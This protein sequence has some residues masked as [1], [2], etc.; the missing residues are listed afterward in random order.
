MGEEVISS[1]CDMNI[2]SQDRQPFVVA[3]KFKG[4]RGPVTFKAERPDG[5]GGQ[6]NG[7]VDAGDLQALVCQTRQGCRR[8]LGC[9]RAPLCRHRNQQTSPTLT[10]S[11]TADA[12]TS[13]DQ[14][15]EFFVILDVIS[16][17]INQLECGC[18]CD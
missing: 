16:S 1:G 3:C 13:L 4:T 6:I 9:P 15:C 2:A 7:L 5:L 12:H 8:Q 11:P 18:H 14:V 10:F 17:S